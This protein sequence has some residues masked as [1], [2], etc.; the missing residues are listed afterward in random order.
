MIYRTETLIEADRDAVWRCLVA[1]NDAPAHVPYLER[2]TL[3][4]GPDLSEGDCVHL[5]FDYLG[6]EFD[7]EAVVVDLEPGEALGLRAVR[8]SLGLVV[9]ARW[10]LTDAPGGTRVEMTIS[11]TIDS[12]LAQL[13]ARALIGDKVVQDAIAAS[14]ATFSTRVTTGACG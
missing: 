5:W 8:P 10:D 14:L 13:G 3:V 1:L 2:A 12:L 6:H 11:L 7:G 9:D 4:A